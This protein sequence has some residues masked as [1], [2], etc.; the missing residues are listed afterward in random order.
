[1]RFDD[2]VA[3]ILEHHRGAHAISGSSSTRRTVVDIGVGSLGLSLRTGFSSGVA[4][5]TGTEI[6]GSPCPRRRWTIGGPRRTVPRAMDH[7]QTEPGA[8][9]HALG[10]KNGSMTRF[11]VASSM[12]EPDC[13]RRAVECTARA[14]AR[15]DARDN[16]FVKGERDVPPSGIASRAFNA[17]FRIGELEFTRV[18]EHRLDLVAPWIEALPGPSVPPT[19]PEGAASLRPVRAPR[20][21]A[22]AGP[23]APGESQ[24]PLRQ[25]RTPLRALHRA[26][27]QSLTRVGRCQM[28]RFRVEIGDHGHEKVVEVMRDA[29]GELAEVSS[30]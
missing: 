15:S 30:F 20:P 14:P 12:P 16:H 4:A 3:E 11:S 2:P 24:Q 29:A 13:L 17:R 23:D 18:D 27:H 6:G 9:A 10:R 7:R 5:V 28:R 1:M 26:V 25:R 22:A 19:A 21:L 8:L